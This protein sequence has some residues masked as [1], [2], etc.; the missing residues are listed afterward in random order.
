MNSIDDMK[1]YVRKNLIRTLAQ[2]MIVISVIGLL[3]LLVSS[4]LPAWREGTDYKVQLA[5]AQETLTAQAQ[6]NQDSALSTSR[7]LSSLQTKL[8]QNASAFLSE[9]EAAALLNTVYHYAD[10]SNVKID[11]VQAV[12]PHVSSKQ[13]PTPGVFE[14]QIFRLEASGHVSDLLDFV[15]RF[16][17]APAPAVSIHNLSITAKKQSDG[18]IF[19][20]TMDLVIYT[21]PYASGHG[22]PETPQTQASLAPT[23]APAASQ[24]ELPATTVSAVATATPTA[25]LSTP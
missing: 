16:K 10:Q 19:D 25:A 12:T 13:T 24:T 9:S 1:F 8:D 11:N 4:V 22:S 3:A 5:E 18:V 15:S 7:K 23:L 2:G 14:M 20:L 6:A 21:S 17:E